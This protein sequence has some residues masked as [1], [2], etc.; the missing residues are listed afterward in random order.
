MRL[1]RRFATLCP[2]ARGTAVAIGNFD[3]VHR[4]HRQVIEA[5]AAM[6][7]ASGTRLGAVTFEPHPREVVRPGEVVSRLTT[8]ARKAELLRE[9]GV[10]QLVV[11]PF[12]RALMRFQPDLL[13]VGL[14]ELAALEGLQ[15]ADQRRIEPRA[16]SL[17]PFPVGIRQRLGG[18]RQFPLMKSQRGRRF[19]DRVAEQSKGVQVVQI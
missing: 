2:D 5:A 19:F 12:D 7:R 8:F 4:G 15:F 1:H 11:L 13:D 18:R 9:L 14:I 3:G 6:A 10:E 17:F 16:P